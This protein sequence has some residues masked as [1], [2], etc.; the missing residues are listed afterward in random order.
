ME[1]T[2][3]TEAAATRQGLRQVE[4]PDAVRAVVWET[5]PGAWWP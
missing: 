1:V 5:Q 3:D 4:L 2:A